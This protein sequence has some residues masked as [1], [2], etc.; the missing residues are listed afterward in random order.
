MLKSLI[1]LVPVLALGVAG[2]AYWVHH[3]CCSSRES[4]TVTDVECSPCCHGDL[5]TVKCPLSTESAGS[6]DKESCCDA[7]PAPKTVAKSAEE[8][9][10]PLCDAADAAPRTKVKAADLVAPK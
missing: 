2:A 7:C 5:D 6:Q 4:A 1:G 3:D 9:K 10:C 8:P